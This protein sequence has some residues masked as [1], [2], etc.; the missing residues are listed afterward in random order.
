MAEAI[1]LIV[2]GSGEASEAEVFDL[3]EDVYPTDA[4]DEVGLVVPVDKDLFSKTVQHAVAWFGKDKD[5]IAVQ[6]NGASLS[7]ASAKLGDGNE[8]VEKFSDILDPG[9]FEEWDE[10]HFLVAMPEPDEDDYETYADLVEV[11]ISNGIKVRDLTKALDDVVLEDEPAAE[12]EP[13]PEPEKP[14]RRSRHKEA[15]PDPEVEK[16]EPEPPKRTRATRTAKAEVV[17]DPPAKAEDVQAPEPEV[18][19]SQ[20]PQ[21]IFYEA[22]GQIIESLQTLRGIYAPAEAEKVED[23]PTRGRGRPREHFE[24]PQIW[25]EEKDEWVPRPKGRMK[26]GT[27]W[28]KIH[29]ETGDVLE[30]GTV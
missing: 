26:R 27:T 29:A 10:V 15:E 25:D 24:V 5:V 11:A 30:E 2:A 13:D 12:P 20:V 4:Y 28:R 18:K 16:D 23:K 9:E 14:A 3:L 19:A 17:D 8:K 21:E 7:R 22:L 1:A 6:T